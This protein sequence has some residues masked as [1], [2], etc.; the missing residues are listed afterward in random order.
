MVDALAGEFTQV[1]GALTADRTGGDAHCCSDL[2]EPPV[3]G[4]TDVGELVTEHRA[5]KRCAR[6]SREDPDSI[7]DDRCGPT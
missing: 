1:D 7:V 6:T 5:D 3:R 4:S 2:S